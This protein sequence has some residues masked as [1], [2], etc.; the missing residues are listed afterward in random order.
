MNVRNA[1]LSEASRSLIARRAVEGPAVA[2]VLHPK[3]ERL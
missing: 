2:W 1:I 3:Q